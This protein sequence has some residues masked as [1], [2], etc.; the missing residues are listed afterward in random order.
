MRAEEFINEPDSMALALAVQNMNLADKQLEE[1]D[2][3]YQ[4]V[5]KHYHEIADEAALAREHWRAVN[6]DSLRDSITYC[7]QTVALHAGSIMIM[8]CDS[9]AVI[10]LNGYVGDGNYRQVQLSREVAKR[11]FYG[12]SWEYNGVIWYEVE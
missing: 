8:R 11:D 1:A 2:V 4:A 7:R 6:N 5:R 9:K 10:W 12:N 3:V